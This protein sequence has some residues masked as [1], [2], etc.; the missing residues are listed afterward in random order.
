MSNPSSA[1]GMV[2]IDADDL[3]RRLDMRAAIDAIAAALAGG[4]DVEA[5][6][7]RLVAPAGA[8]ELLCMPAAWRGWAGV[9]VAS[10]APANPSVGRP[11]IQGAY[12]LTDSATLT[13]L[14]LIDGPALTTL[15]TPA[16]SGV[17]I[18]RLARPGPIDLV[19]WGTGPQAGGHIEAVR[20]VRDV[21]R[22]GV[23]GRD[24]DRAAA[25]A[26]G[27]SHP[28]SEVVVLSPAAV[29]DALAQADVVCCATTSTEPLFDAGRIRDDAVV[30]AVG[31]HDP[32]ARE[33]PSDLMGRGRVVVESRTSAMAE[34]GDV[35]MAVDDGSLHRDDLTDL[36]ELVRSGPPTGPGPAVV[37]TTGM[38]WEDLVVAAAAAD[39]G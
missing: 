26:S 35:V 25:F 33:L 14:A 3:A 36:A 30:V 11:R 21:R 5:A 34:A 24:A 10:V 8:G 18:D 27:W 6:T 31:S 29:P 20:A 37:K 23:V 12:L 1:L 2:V 19:V 16:V 13:P 32:R 39:A 4:L 22:I 7:P 38:A 15:R 9:K 17:A 28:T